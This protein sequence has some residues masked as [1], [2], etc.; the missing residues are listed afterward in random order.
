MFKDS[1]NNMGLAPPHHIKGN[2]DRLFGKGEWKDW[3]LETISMELGLVLDELTRDKISLLQ[4]IEKDPELL[5]GDMAFFLHAVDVM[6]NKVA[7][8]EYLPLPTSLELAYAIEES[9]NLEVP[10]GSFNEPNSDIVEV[11][12]YL[13][14]EEG[15]SEPVY[16]FTFVPAK[17]LV[18]GQTPQETDD[19]RKAIEIYIKHM[20]E[21]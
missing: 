19:K 12:T 21:L 13:L 9:K 17:A 20:N 2:L 14:R 3:E 11:V 5:Y 4:A 10:K 8:F 6:N 18:P 16:P 7:D 15:Y 1:D